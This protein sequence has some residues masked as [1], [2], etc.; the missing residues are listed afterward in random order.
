MFLLAI[1]ATKG[2]VS[3]SVSLLASYTSFRTSSSAT[4][5]GKVGPYRSGLRFT[6]LE[7]FLHSALFC[8]QG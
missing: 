2:S 3:F 4:S 1:F 7:H 8:S 6:L 5:S